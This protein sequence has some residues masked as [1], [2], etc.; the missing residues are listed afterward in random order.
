MCGATGLGGNVNEQAAPA[1]PVGVGDLVAADHQRWA[2]LVARNLI[3]AISELGQ[4]DPAHLAGPAVVI[5]HSDN[6]QAT[7]DSKG[8]EVLGQLGVVRAFA[9]RKLL[10]EIH[11]M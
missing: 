8:R 1:W 6:Q 4:F 11:P 5:L 10:L 7:V 2:D 9:D 3:H